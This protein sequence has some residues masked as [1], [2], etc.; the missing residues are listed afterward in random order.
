MINIKDKRILLLILVLI[1]VVIAVWYFRGSGNSYN[2]REAALKEMDE[3]ILVDEQER[4]FKTTDKVAEE[5]DKQRISILK[6]AYQVSA[7][8]EGWKFIGQEIRNFVETENLDIPFVATIT[9][10]LQNPEKD[11]IYRYHTK[12]WGYLPEEGWK[13]MI[14][15]VSEYD[16]ETRKTI[17]SFN[18]ANVWDGDYDK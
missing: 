2:P 10:A 16:D 1:V 13:P 15:G 6:K 4:T 18:S 5:I 12:T 11:N 3:S 14:E 17:R 7:D 9:T 8:A